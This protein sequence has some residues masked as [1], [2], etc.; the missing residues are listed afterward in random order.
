MREPLIWHLKNLSRFYKQGP[1]CKNDCC[2]HEAGYYRGDKEEI[3]IMIKQIKSYP[4]SV[5]IL[6]PK[7]SIIWKRD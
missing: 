6:N 4:D 5:I 7:N 3:D 2:D 1:V